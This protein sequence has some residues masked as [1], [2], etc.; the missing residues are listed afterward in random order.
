MGYGI[1][2]EPLRVLRGIEEGGV[3]RKNRNVCHI[4]D[5]REAGFENH[6]GTGPNQEAG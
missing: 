5:A 1:L 3:E 2:R 4:V 6:K